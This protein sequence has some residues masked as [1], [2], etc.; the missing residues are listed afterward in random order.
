MNVGEIRAAIRARGFESDTAAEQLIFLNT[1]QRRLAGSTRGRW[2]EAATTVAVTAGTGDFALPSAPA[3]GHVKSVHLA[4]GTSGAPVL[5]DWL[6]AEALRDYRDQDSYVVR[7]TPR[8][9]TLSAP[10]TISLYP[11]ADQAGTLT[12]V[13]N[14]VPP[15]LTGDSD[16]PILPELY[17]D[18]LVV[19]S[20][21]L[22]AQRE[23]Q[24]DAV[25][26]FNAEFE[27]L[28]GDMRRQLGIE[29]QQSVQ[30]VQ[31][32]GWYD[33]GYSGC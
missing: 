2:T 30:T 25:A 26:D 13:Y 14:R 31:S 27:E 19:G 15:A 32:S 12:V 20:C 33:D 22:V 7:A 10:T 9:W 23:R 17:H 29:Q 6:D 18:L 11:A 3:G 5:L 24:R 1:V 28:H 16:T 21:R 4:Y 8:F